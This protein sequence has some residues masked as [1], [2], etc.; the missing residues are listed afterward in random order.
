[1]NDHIIRKVETLCV[2]CHTREEAAKIAQTGEGAEVEV[3]SVDYYYDGNLI[4]DV[5]DIAQLYEPAPY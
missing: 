2:K 3:L 4:G 5:D 1:M